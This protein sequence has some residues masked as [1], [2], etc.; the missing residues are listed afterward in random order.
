MKKYIG[1]LILIAILLGSAYGQGTSEEKKMTLQGGIGIS[2]LGIVGNTK[3]IPF[4]I[5]LGYRVSK[6][7]SLGIYAGLH[8]TK[9]VLIEAIPGSLEQTGFNYIITSIGARALYHVNF[10]ENKK[11][12]TYGIVALGYC[13]ISS[14]VFGEMTSEMPK[15][16]FI[17]YGFGGGIRYF[18]APNVGAFF[19]GGYGAGIDLL[20]IGISL[21]L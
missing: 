21:K 18:F 16:S 20:A 4:S 7:V 6:E 13:I 10:F 12:D 5:S 8:S 3:G 14:S 1:L 2:P 9:C 19:E 17:M 15:Q 11:I